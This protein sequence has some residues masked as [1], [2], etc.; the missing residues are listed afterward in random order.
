[1]TPTYPVDGRG[2]DY[3]EGDIVV[4]VCN[5]MNA[6]LEICVVTKVDSNKVYLNNSRVPLTFPGRCL[7]VTKLFLPEE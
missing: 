6:T 1:M 3:V 5:T 2:K 7:I 4:R